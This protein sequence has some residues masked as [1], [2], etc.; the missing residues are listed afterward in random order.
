MERVRTI[1]QEAYGFSIHSQRERGAA[2]VLETD[3]GL[4]YLYS[5]PTACRQKK[6]LIDR[7]HHLLEENS[8]LRPLTFSETMLGKR[9]VQ[10][11]AELYYVQ[12]GVREAVPD[13]LPFATGQALA[14]FHQATATLKGDPLYM[15]FRT[16]GAW[17]SMW[18]KRLRRY[19][20]YRDQLEAVEREIT[21]IDEHLLTSYTY[22]HHLGDTA[23]Q[24]LKDTGYQKVV[25]ETAKCG[26]VTYQNFDHGFILFTEDG[27]R[28]VS[29]QYAWALDMRSRDIG[30]WLKADIRANGWDPKRVRA[31][32]Q[33]YN[34]VAPLIE[35]EYSVIYALL[36]FPGRFLRYAELYDRLTPEVRAELDGSHWQE[37][38]DQE[39]LVMGEAACQYPELV[40]EDFGVPV[41]PVPWSWPGKAAVSRAAAAGKRV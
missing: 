25:K 26:K 10:D 41:Q 18:R 28:Y 1:L 24:Y 5:C 32:L 27:S 8:K 30:Q 33:G 39:L 12:P 2:T 19:E 23:I 37:L 9:L 34:R 35:A 31:F 11:G 15:P 13:N 20:S 22:V 36:L 14:E 17:P 4:F 16:L 7:V 40:K 21:P 29:G 6:R 38:L 3:R